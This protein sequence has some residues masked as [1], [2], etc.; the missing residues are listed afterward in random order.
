MSDTKAVVKSVDMSEE[1]Q[2][3]AIECSTQALEKYNIEKDIAAHIKREFDRKYGPTWHCVVGRNFGS[4]V[5][6]VMVVVFFGCLLAKLGY[7]NMDKQ[8]WLSKVN[9]V[10]FTPC[11]LFSNIASVISL[12]KLL[13]Y[14]PIPFFYFVYAI[15]NY[16]ASQIITRAIGLSSAYR[17]FVLACVMFSNSNS[18][19]IAIISSLAVSEA[20]HI[21]YWGENDTTEAVA[22]RGI[23]YTLFFAIFGNLIRWSY[24]YHLLQRHNGDEEVVVN[25]TDYQ[26]ISSD[27]RLPSSSSSSSSLLLH[28]QEATHP[29]HSK[30]PSRQLSSVT[31]T[32]IADENTNLLSQVNKQAPA[33]ETSS[34]LMILLAKRI[35]RFMS[36]P[37]YAA[38]A[39]LIIGLTPPLKS[40][41]YNKQSF[42]YP[43]FTKAVESCGK[44]AVPII[45]T[46]LGAQLYSISKSQHETSPAMKKPVVTAIAIRMCLM[47]FLVVPIIIL[48]VLYG[49][50]FSSLASDPVFV[51]MM[52]VLGCAPT[53]INLVQITQVNNI[54]E[55]EMLRMLFWSYG[56]VCI[57]LCTF[58][59]F[60]ALNVVDRML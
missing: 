31:I 48:F 57:P 46:C 51:T 3:E 49:S 59:V 11:L 29:S 23:S 45:L 27:T 2:Q 18:L 12:S 55:E 58:V 53:A 8:K 25:Y 22:A 54:F 1:M 10:F 19:P 60:L 16:G 20:A 44:A 28:D 17:R 13:A 21:L 24:G 9:L 47:P 52:I 26:T 56:V 41:L 32:V 15:L 40:I 37:L 50:R 39:A 34:N 35:N 42:L 6:H 4:F 36:P 43:S 30:L 14:W 33:P 7:F 38:I 5:T